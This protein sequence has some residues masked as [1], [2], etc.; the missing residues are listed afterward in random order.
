MSSL[1]FRSAG[2]DDLS[3][4]LEIWKDGLEIF[5]SKDIDPEPLIAAFEVNFKNRKHYFNFWVACNGGVLGWCSILPAF[6]HPLKQKKSAEVSI[7]FRKEHSAKGLGRK[8]M[9]YVFSEIQ[10]S[11]LEIVWGFAQMQNMASIKMC[12]N[13]G[14]KICGQTSNRVILVKEFVK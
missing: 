7:Y 14:M 13:A 6:S 1:I 12:E 8:L 10:E 3:D 9:K 4:I 11:E 2:D 5:R